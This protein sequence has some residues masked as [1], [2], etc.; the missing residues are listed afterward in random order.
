MRI[1]FVLNPVSGGRSKAEWESGIKNYYKDTEHTYELYLTNGQ[2]DRSSLTHWIESWKPDRVV[3]VGGD[4]TLK[5][6]A[7]I[8]ASNEIPLGIL[9]AG[10]ANGMARELGLPAS[11][12]A[13][14]DIIMGDNI[15][16]IDT[17]KINGKDTC[18]HLSDIGLNAQLVKYFEENG[19]R[20][21]LGYARGLLRVL[22]NKKVLHVRIETEQESLIRDA[23][24]VVLANARMYGTGAMINPKG[25]LEDGVFEVIIIR[26][27][28]ISAFMKILF[29]TRNFNPDKIEILPAKSVV[30]E[31][32]KKA[33]FQIDGEYKGQTKAIK[34]EVQKQVLPIML[35]VTT[36]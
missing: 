36:T 3:A 1:L 16:K 8:L 18:L 6:V 25:N 17:I 11:L 28:S 20:G 14:L 23:F 2:N 21:K 19:W 27:L 22:I 15:R 7:E 33:Y 5:L 34:A 24:M 26:K 10:S 13:C 31:V 9:P 29:R 4:G 32:K 35:P 30:I 12:E